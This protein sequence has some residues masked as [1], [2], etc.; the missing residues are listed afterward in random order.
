MTK[1]SVRNT[2]YERLQFGQS[3]S[4]QGR[5]QVRNC[6]PR[7]A[8]SN[9]SRSRAWVGSRLLQG[10]GLFPSGKLC[11]T[12]CSFAEDDNSLDQKKCRTSE[13]WVRRCPRL[14]YELLCFRRRV[15][16]VWPFVS[17]FSIQRDSSGV[18]AWSVQD[19]CRGLGRMYLSQQYPWGVCLMAMRLLNGQRWPWK[20]E[21]RDRDM[22]SRRLWVIWESR[23][24]VTCWEQTWP[25][26]LMVP[27]F[28]GATEHPHLSCGL[29]HPFFKWLLT[30]KVERQHQCAML[31]RLC[32]L[33][34][35]V[36]Q[37]AAWEL[38]LQGPKKETGLTSVSQTSSCDTCH[39]SK[40]MVAA[41]L[42][43]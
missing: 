22:F 36:S 40:F 5:L 15:W 41:V 31:V 17:P 23:L 33:L 8:R 18:C 12:A 35:V 1:Q 9:L 3:S 14:A 27:I 25:V 21:A 32:R 10:L 6:W 28:S 20:T 29:W 24:A 37:A 19:M 30:N 26:G 13:A 4:I 43:D 34:D 38:L 39:H 16:S 42:T 11:E 7:M 2:S